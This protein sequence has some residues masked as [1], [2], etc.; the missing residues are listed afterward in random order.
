MVEYLAEQISRPS[1]LQARLSE[2][3]AE[4]WELAAVVHTN[5][6]IFKRTPP[7]AR[8]RKAQPEAKVK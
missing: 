3:G 6:F 7:K 2:L 8:K 5:H 1:N 4:D